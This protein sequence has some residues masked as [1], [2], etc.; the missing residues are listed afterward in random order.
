MEFILDEK[1]KFAE[2]WMTNA[3]QADP[4]VEA[5]AQRLC[6]EWHAKGYLPVI[7]RSGKEDLYEMTSALLVSNRNRMARRE[8]EADRAAQ[9]GERQSVLALLDQPV[10]QKASRS[11][12]SRLHDIS[13]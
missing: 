11:Q 9:K 12:K 3:D 5:Q 7:Y 13:R 10:P 6:K 8:A 1:Q 4:A 2:I